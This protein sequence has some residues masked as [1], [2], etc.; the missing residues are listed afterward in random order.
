MKRKSAR[1]SRSRSL[2]NLEIS[3]LNIMEA[4]DDSPMFRK[5][6]EEAEEV[7]S[8]IQY[9]P[10]WYLHCLQGIVRVCIEVTANN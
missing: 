8:D 10:I 1:R 5:Q 6:V 3:P 4:L 9:T 7:L 2:L